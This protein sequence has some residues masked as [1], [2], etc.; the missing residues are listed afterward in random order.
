MKIFIVTAHLEE[1]SF[2]HALSQKAKFF[3]EKQGHTV[4]QS[5]LYQ[6]N[7]D[8]NSGRE[9]YL[10]SADSAYFKQ[11]AEEQYAFDNN[12]FNNEI[13]VELD[14][15]LSS[16]L[17]ILQFPL[18]WCSVP[19]ILK[20]WIDKVFAF[21]ATY[22]NGKWFDN[23]VLSGKRALLSLTTGGPSTMYTE[24]GLNGDLEKILFHLNHGTLRFVGYDI[25]KPFTSWGVSW[26]SNEQREKY[27][28]D[29]EDYLSNIFEKNSLSY[30]SL[31]MYDLNTF[32]LK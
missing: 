20:S 2:N 5:N 18:T 30:P 32:E 3:F 21:G 13:S 28:S 14:K 12:Q 1:K 4:V 8:P 27:L 25:I 17:L 7:W 23:G 15:L 24:Q 22:G 6:M 26:C 9:N 29:Y 16:D 11:Q 19:S 31:D 10:S